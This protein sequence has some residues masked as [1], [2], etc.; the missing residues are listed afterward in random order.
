MDEDVLILTEPLILRAG[1]NVRHGCGGV[2]ERKP[3]VIGPSAL[4][5]HCLLRPRVRWFL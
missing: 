3:N 5:L 2:I 1:K 4:L